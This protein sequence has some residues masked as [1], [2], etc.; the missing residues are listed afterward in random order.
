ML[1]DKNVGRVK[2]NLYYVKEVC[3][4]EGKI[5]PDANMKRKL[6]NQI[7]FNGLKN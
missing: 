7:D 5:I 2:R 1:F 6:K 3:K 4:N